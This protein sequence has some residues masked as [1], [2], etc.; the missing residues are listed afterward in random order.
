M[1]V[2]DNRRPWYARTWLH[3]AVILA[4]AAAFRLWRID[5]IP[6]GLFGD[7]ATD[8]L[9]ALDVLAGRGGVFFPANFGREGLHM[10][11]V[12]LAFRLLG[13]TPLA[14]RLPSAIAGI[15]TALA[16][17][18]LGR[19]LGAKEEGRLKKEEVRSKEARSKK[20]EIP[21]SIFLF[22]SSFF[23][24]SFVT[25]LAALYIATSYWHVHF[26]RF[27]IRGVFTPLCGALAFA[28]FWRA[29]NRGSA[30]WFAV[31]GFWLGLAT[32]FYTASRFFP[33]FLAGFLA[34]Q[35]ALARLTRGPA[36]LPRCWR[37][38]LLMYATAA[39]VFA[40]LGLYFLQHPGSFAQRASAVAALGAESP[41]SR[42]AQ[43]ALANVLQFFAPGRG[44]QEQFYNLPGRAVFDPASALLALLGLGVLLRRWRKGPAL[45]LMLWF[46]AL[47]LPSFLATDRWPT[48]PRVLGV[49]PGVYFFPAIGLA[50]ALG[51][52]ARRSPSLP[53]AARRAGRAAGIALLCAA[54]LLHAGLTWRDYFHVWGPSQATFDAFEGDMAAAWRWL[55]D[56]PDV[57]RPAHVYLSSDIY[58]H[59]T[60]MLL[61]E[62]ATVQTYFTHTNP[63]LSWFDGRAALPLPAGGQP[64]L[65]LVSSAAPLAPRAD[66]W[67]RAAA[68]EIDTVAGP[69]GAP[70]LRVFRAQPGARIEPGVAAGAEPVALTAQLDLSAAQLALADGAEPELTL[71][72]RTRGPDPADWPGYR[73]EAALPARDGTVWADEL[74][75]EAFRPLEWT[76]DAAFV[77]WH[78]LHGYAGPA[79]SGAAPV[80]GELRLVRLSDGGPEGWRTVAF[81]VN[82]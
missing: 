14:L 22:S 30:A 42:M 72:W 47:L 75:F 59:P 34:V 62:R 53:A 61:H 17:Y 56:H 32:H 39:L 12:A 24:S 78:T 52:L 33:F 60:F 7:E 16:T 51:W 35:W 73:L 2:T 31:A 6:P 40:P 41:L 15:L 23:S 45:F 20:E 44:D 67:L 4:V 70:A 1:P 19:E 55:A 54:L 46:P 29:I 8:G 65:Y 71:L 76:P 69:D 79:A 77:T 82:H 66:G 5:S 28:A 74:P 13:V 43:A 68:A 37:G 27:G 49:I 80:Q 11:I 57:S 58:R 26:S 10:W 9:D 48:L 21:S 64:T 50:A 18:W 3:I 36:I 63:Q 25:L 38:I 81:S